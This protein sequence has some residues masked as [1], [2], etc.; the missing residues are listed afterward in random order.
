[1]LC[2]AMQVINAI[3]TSGLIVT[4]NDGVI[5]HANESARELLGRDL[6]PG[7]CIQCVCPEVS[8]ILASPNRDGACE[9]AIFPEGPDNI[10]N[11]APSAR[12]LRVSCRPLCLHD[13]ITRDYVMLELEDITVK[14]TLAERIK[15]LSSVLDRAAGGITIID[16]DLKIVSL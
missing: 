8:G 7:S 6:P 2:Q 4:E 5:V 14:S 9:F 1:M 13:G 16:P 10:T 15:F 12:R 11:G 3:D